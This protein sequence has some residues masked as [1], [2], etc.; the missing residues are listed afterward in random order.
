MRRAQCARLGSLVAAVLVLAGAGPAAAG[1]FEVASCQ[2]DRVN[3][4]TTA[5]D[6]FAT[7]G[8]KIRRACN[9]EG[10]GLRG[11]ITANAISSASVPR[12]SV[13]MAAINAP[14]GTR[15]TSFRWAGSVW[16]RDC[17][18]AL[19][20]YADA[21][22]IQPIAIKNVRANQQCGGRGRVQAAG[23]RSRTFNVSGAT[24]IVQRVI[25]QGG[26]DSRSC[27]ARAAN[28]I[29]TYQAVVGIADTQ[30][31]IAAIVADT[32]FARGEWVSGS[33]PLNYDAS[34]NVGVRAAHALVAGRAAGSDQR[35]CL[36]ASAGG[37]FANGVPCPNGPGQ[38][39][40][41]T[42]RLLE[43]TQQAVIQAEDTAGNL[44]SSDAVAARIDNT[45]PG[46]V[47]VAVEAGEGWRNRNDFTVGWTNPPEPDRAPITTASYKL[48]QASGGTCSQG[49]QAG[50]DISRL[51]LQLPAP[52]EWTLFVWRRDAAGNQAPDAASVPVTLRYDPEPPQLGFE[53]PPAGDPTLVS[54]QVIDK[55]SGLADG[56]IEI[57]PAGS[58]TWQTLPTQKD[59]SRLVARIDDAAM[60]AG[61]YLLR[62]TARDQA[63]NEASTSQRL[64]GQPMTVTLPLRTPSTMQ[65]GVVG[66]RIVKQTVVVHGKRRRVRRRVNVLKP[67]AR[68]S[69]GQ[70][71]QIS[72]RLATRDGQPI[73]GAEVQVLSA[74]DS[75]PEQQ[76]A[77]V[78]TDADGTY[79]Y[80][81]PA[82]ASRTLRFVYLDRAARS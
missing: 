57:S 38:L 76:V 13:A 27:S 30:A 4:S 65:A 1:Q 2:A 63:S 42:T 41:D 62:A 59:A 49:E 46:R 43:G 52:G 50:A 79:A 34:D 40:V 20:L 71:V 53:A 17:R 31:P 25:C 44:G 26:G 23:Y 69:F 68:V 70:R 6:D 78:Q 54:V 47:A 67:R 37:A 48:C 55:V 8:M 28:Y 61:T 64:D 12:G 39:G 7:R 18:Y 22:D 9:P 77:V 19:Q 14:P 56:S 66:R 80:A 60:P 75:S 16:R 21:P 36:L 45:P 81:A 24:R 72:G 33:Q 35:S 58:G 29:R 32:P 11:L 10:P 51:G 82:S 15:F 74:S 5:F 3:F 73:V